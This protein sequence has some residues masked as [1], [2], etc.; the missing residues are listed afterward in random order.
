[1]NSNSQLLF[2]FKFNKSYLDQ[3]YF[4]SSSNKEA[5]KIINSWPKWI[6]KTINLHGEKY[7]GKSHLAS[8]F[9]RK[10]T[11]I[12]VFSKD[13]GEKL[14]KFC[15]LQSQKTKMTPKTQTK[16]KT[17]NVCERKWTHRSKEKENS[18]I[19]LSM[20]WYYWS[21]TSSS[22]DNKPSQGVVT[23]PTCQETSVI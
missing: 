8:I 22:F 23:L 17:S 11:C 2:N 14:K 15:T 21:K 5:F 1:M 16:Q 7:S 10:T 6:K 12:K 13:F 9:E 18:C 20:R 3:D 19:K 4:L